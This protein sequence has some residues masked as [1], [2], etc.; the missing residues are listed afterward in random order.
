MS[1][2]SPVW[3][4]SAGL[5]DL[6]ENLILFV[7]L[8]NFFSAGLGGGKDG[9]PAGERRVRRQQYQACQV[10]VLKVLSML[11]ELIVLFCQLI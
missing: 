4:T 10:R 9:S 3:S 1:V 5:I 7:L 11:T 2:P 6:V 8:S